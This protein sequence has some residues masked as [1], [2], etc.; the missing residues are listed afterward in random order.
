M[1]SGVAVT[2]LRACSGRPGG[3]GEL[4]VPCLQDYRPRVD[5]VK[6]RTKEFY[7]FSQV[8]TNGMSSIPYV[9]T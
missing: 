1:I 8:A 3:G 2:M 6:I 4:G 7:S 9:L 5:V